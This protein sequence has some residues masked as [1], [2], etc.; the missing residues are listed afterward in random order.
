[1]VWQS[2]R[3]WIAHTRL[4]DR[5]LNNFIRTNLVE[6]MPGK[7]TVAGQYFVAEGLNRIGARQMVIATASATVSTTS[8]QSWVQLS[9]GPAATVALQGTSALVFFGC[10]MNL[11]TFGTG[12]FMTVDSGPPPFS[13]RW[14]CSIVNNPGDKQRHMSYHLFTGLTPGLVTFTAWYSVASPNTCT[15]TDRYMIVIP[16]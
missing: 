6:T 8:F 5:D 10:A 1:M 12:A 13:G 16:L 15:F 9:G 2:P 11:S 4:Y 7:A 14:N 3:T